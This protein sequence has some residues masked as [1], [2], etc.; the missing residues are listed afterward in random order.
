M[1]I[2]QL[3]VVLAITAC[4]PAKAPPEAAP[5]ATTPAEPAPTGHVA[6]PFTAADLAAGLPVGT[7]LKLRVVAAGE[8][9]VVQHWIWTESD[10]E[11]CTIRGL[12]LAE[13]GQTVLTDS[14]GRS[15]W[16]ELETHAH[17]PA[18]LTT[19]SESSIEVE[20]GTFDTW[21]FDVQAA[22]PGDPVKV[23]HFARTL[24]GPP[25]LMEHTL[26]GEVVLRMELVSRTQP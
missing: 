22:G 15:S 25:V 7:E 23:Y 10:A 21:R 6:P 8:P 16:A 2:A 9:T 11:G 12:L 19:M 18:A 13:D 17:F 20:A 4:G 5:V 14:A 3:V 1:R 26:D 24:P